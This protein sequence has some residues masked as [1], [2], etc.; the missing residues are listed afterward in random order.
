MINFALSANPNV[1]EALTIKTNFDVAKIINH[2][3]FIEALNSFIMIYNI[4]LSPFSNKSNIFT[5]N[6]L[7][8]IKDKK[9]PDYFKNNTFDKTAIFDNNNK[10]LS[11]TAGIFNTV[12]YSAN[13]PSYV[14]I[15]ENSDLNKLKADFDFINKKQID[16]TLVKKQPEITKIDDIKQCLKVL[17]FL[18]KI[19]KTSFFDEAQH[20]GSTGSKSANQF[21]IENFLT[22]DAS[23]PAKTVLSGDGLKFINTIL[24]H[25]KIK[26]TDGK[27][28]LELE[29]GDVADLDKI[30]EAVNDIFTAVL[31][32]E[33]KDGF[34]VDPLTKV[35]N[36][37]TVNKGTASVD[38][39]NK[40]TEA[41][42]KNEDANFTKELKTMSVFQYI[43]NKGYGSK[44][45]TIDGKKIHTKI[46]QE[47]SKDVEY[48]V[49]PTKQMIT[50]SGE[51]VTG[52]II[53]YVGW[54][55]LGKSDNPSVDEMNEAAAA[56]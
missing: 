23:S 27:N 21:D 25:F 22:K 20:L 41:E 11:K 28:D 56:D 29:N 17:K 8:T 53:G 16:N 9:N 1:R 38:N 42:V 48:E 34:V 39:T 43:L 14:D 24:K 2:D 5:Y 33:V 15:D 52:G 49:N 36:N 7:F 31:K 35:D 45:T 26:T 50:T 55:Q 40:T 6:D 30:K 47:N 54:K 13:I 4:S 10:L 44:E 18:K 19:V 32:E 51:V 3:D 37:T 46:I 12:A